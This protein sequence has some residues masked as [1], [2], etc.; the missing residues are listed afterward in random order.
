MYGSMHNSCAQ[1][2]P[3]Y[4]NTLSFPLGKPPEA[5]PSPVLKLPA[6]SVAASCTV[7]RWWENLPES[8]MYNVQ[9]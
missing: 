4:G 2:H 5:G 9:V 3:P 6:V 1:L 7:V 8:V